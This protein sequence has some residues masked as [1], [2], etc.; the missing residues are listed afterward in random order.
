M[1]PPTLILA[2]QGGSSWGMLL[3]MLIVVV[4]L[5]AMIVGIVTLAWFLAKCLVG[6]STHTG[7]PRGLKRH[8]PKVE[9]DYPTPSEISPPRS[10]D[11]AGRVPD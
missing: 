1:H 3:M 11:R 4:V 9:P 6:W 5:V 2:M 7:K 10:V 8:D